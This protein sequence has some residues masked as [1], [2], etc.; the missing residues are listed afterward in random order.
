MTTFYVS[1]YLAIEFRA[2]RRQYDEEEEEDEEGGKATQ[3]RQLAALIRVVESAQRLAA[4][5]SAH[6]SMISEHQITSTMISWPP[7]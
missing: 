3:G 4:T 6:F 1:C 7:F 2:M 5:F